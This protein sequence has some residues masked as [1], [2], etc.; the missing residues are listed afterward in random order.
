MLTSAETIDRT[1]ANF[2]GSGLTR[3]ELV[4][5]VAAGNIRLRLTDAQNAA[6]VDATELKILN[7]VR[8]RI[9][10][11]V[12]VWA[13]IAANPST[14]ATGGHDQPDEMLLDNM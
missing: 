6:E 1:F 4:R 14:V 7:T 13:T 8:N 2:Q 9:H 10:L 11:K 5:C 3:P 12:G